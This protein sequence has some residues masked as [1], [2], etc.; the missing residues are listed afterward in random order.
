MDALKPFLTDNL[1]QVSRDQDERG[2]IEGVYD[3]EGIRVHI[4]FLYKKEDEIESIGKDEDI[5]ISM[6]SG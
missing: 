5:G 2:S 6:R 4:R 1:K 3:D